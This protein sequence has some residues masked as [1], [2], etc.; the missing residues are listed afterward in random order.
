MRSNVLDTYDELVSWFFLLQFK[1]IVQITIKY[2]NLFPVYLNLYGI[3]WEF[4]EW[5]GTG[6]VH[7]HV[8]SLHNHVFSLLVCLLKNHSLHKS[9][10]KQ[11]SDHNY[12]TCFKR[13]NQTPWFQGSW[14]FTTPWHYQS[15]APSH[16]YC[17]RTILLQ[18]YPF[19]GKGLPRA[20]NSD[21]R[22]TAKR[23]SRILLLP[24]PV[25]LSLHL[26]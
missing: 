6:A 3:I 8:V 12:W 11:Y 24:T 7:V 4:W 9:V 2:P 25:S 17:S 16:S 22:H 15:K 21:V 23:K 14:Y 10:E 1:Y 5:S 18:K 19:S 13:M 26:H 20:K